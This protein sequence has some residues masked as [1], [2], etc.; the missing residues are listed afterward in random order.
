MHACTSFGVPVVSC[1]L[2]NW[3]GLQACNVYCH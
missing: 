1:K 3:R 2:I